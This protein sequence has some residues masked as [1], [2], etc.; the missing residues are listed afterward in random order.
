MDTPESAAARAKKLRELIEY[1]NYRYYVLDDPEISD[2]EFDLLMR[3]LESLES[4]YPALVTPDSPTQRV[5]AEPLPAFREVL[6]SI[7]ML[8]LANAFTPGEVE[9]FDRRV[10]EG[11]GLHEV[12]YVAEPKLDGLAVS[13]LYDKGHLIRAATRGDGFHGEDVTQNVRTIPSV[14][15]R[16]MGQGYPAV[17]EVRGEVYMTK[18]GF[19]RL[20]ERQANSGGKLFANPRNAAAGS[21]RQ[22]DPRITAERPLAIFCYGTGQVSEGG[23]PSRHSEILGK[24]KTWGLRVSPDI[25]VVSGV[26]GCLGYYDDMSQRRGD[27]PYETD[28]V[29]YK[30]NDLQQ[31]ADLGF[32]ARAPRWAVAH[33]FAPQEMETIVEAIEVQVG[34]T[35]ALTPVARLKPVFVGGVTVTNATLHNQDEID[36]KD[37]RVGDTV[38]VRRA[39]EVIPEVV[40]VILEKRPPKTERFNIPVVC[41]V[42]GS[43]VVRQ[44]GEA[45]ARC[46]GS[47]ICPAQRIQGILHFASR[48]AM[49]IQGLGDK[50]V[51]QLVSRNEIHDVADLYQLTRDRLEH[52]D[53]MG[54]KSAANL[55]AELEK[56]KSITLGRYLYALGIKDVGEATAR[57]LAEHFGTFDA[58]VEATEETLEAVPDIGPTIAANIAAFFR[59]PRN[60]EI[61]ARLRK[62]GIHWP[63]AGE[64]GGDKSLAGLTFVLTGTLPSMGREEAKKKLLELG[65]K[66]TESVSKKT[67]FVVVGAEPGSKFE[68]ARELGVPILDEA[69]LMRMLKHDRP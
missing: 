34:R 28:G 9:A 29:V 15:L 41:P 37:V 8:S 53:R 19:R 36:R 6:H 35:G 66:V 50:L 17:L 7:P 16:L 65:A 32:V 12:E 52:L 10:R 18:A 11:L 42:C 14:P 58:I 1:H 61:I 57:A 54:E 62:A 69:G 68:R 27:L 59:Q 56:S 51:E 26:A 48:R 40:G 3:E 25:E 21:L 64:R 33:K 5:G 13:L 46:T 39:G 43:P 44:A 45:V 20:N 60:L 4:R 47:L 22:L 24:L 38:L 30:V 67:S 23:L 2:A 49:D 55:M 63:E 31:Q